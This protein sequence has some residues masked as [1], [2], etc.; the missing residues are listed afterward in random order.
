M[1]LELSSDEERSA[2]TVYEEQRLRAAL[3][4]SVLELRDVGDWLM[5]DFLDDVAFLQAG[6]RHLACGVDL[7]DNDALCRFGNAEF[8]GCA[9]IESGDFHAFESFVAALLV[10]IRVSFGGFCWHFGQLDRGVALCTVTERLEFELGAWLH[11]RDAHAE[12][13]A[14]GDGLAVDLEN[15]VACLDARFRR[16]AVGSYVA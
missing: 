13:I 5:V 10:V 15:D 1:Q 16:R 2:L 9:S 6:V 4:D 11:H 7:S 12:L 14:V 8:A 3:A